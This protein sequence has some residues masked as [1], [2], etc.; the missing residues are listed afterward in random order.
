LSKELSLTLRI[1]ELTFARLLSIA[2]AS[3]TYGS[4]TRRFC[5]NAIIVSSARS[6]ALDTEKARCF[7][8]EALLVTRQRLRSLRIL[9]ALQMTMKRSPRLCTL[10]FA[11]GRHHE[12]LQGVATTVMRSGTMYRIQ[13]QSSH[14]G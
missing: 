9:S 4:R 10:S 11:R 14:R 12:S 8:P 7:N 5:L 13:M 6:R 2:Q 1:W 3:E